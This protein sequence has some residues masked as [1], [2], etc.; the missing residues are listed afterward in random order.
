MIEINCHNR[1]SVKDLENLDG[2]IN[3]ISEEANYSKRDL[4]ELKLYLKLWFEVKVGN[5]SDNQYKCRLNQLRHIGNVN[6]Y[7]KYGYLPAEWTTTSYKEKIYYVTAYSSNKIKK[8]PEL[9]DQEKIVYK[10]YGS[11]NYF[12]IKIIDSAH[13]SFRN[14]KMLLEIKPIKYKRT[15]FLFPDEP[16]LIG[17]TYVMDFKRNIIFNTPRKEHPDYH[18][19]KIKLI[20]EK[21]NTLQ[22]IKK[23]LE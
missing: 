19:E 15:S 22:N 9:R 18:L 6:Y 2:V 4:F 14:Q 5:I 17:E 12:D 16:I 7:L 21:I 23:T 20:N 10:K 8:R 3:S 13:Y 1:Y 11:D